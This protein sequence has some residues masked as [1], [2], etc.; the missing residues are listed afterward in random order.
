MGQDL[1]VSTPT[2]G[3]T[4]GRRVRTPGP[5]AV[6]GVL[7][8]TGETPS[9]F[10]SRGCPV[11][12]PGKTRGA[13]GPLDVGEPRVPHLGWWDPTRSPQ[14]SFSGTV[15][16]C[17]P[18]GVVGGGWN[19]LLPVVAG[20]ESSVSPVPQTAGLGTE[21]PRNSKSIFIL[22]KFLFSSTKVN[23][24]C[25]GDTRSGHSSKKSL[26]R[27]NKDPP[28]TI[29]GQTF[30][31]SLFTSANRLH[32]RPTPRSSEPGRD[33]EM[34]TAQGRNVNGGRERGWDTLVGRAP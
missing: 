12:C 5:T 13:R 2:P 1:K 29:A 34:R 3:V 22:C 9:S 16:R 6:T 21:S 27:P 24:V 33:A 7:F 11:S 30:S 23:T 8:P 20:G 25:L 28:P 10:W 32:R 26:N 19:S 31:S 4:E 17:D 18:V 15:R 14:N